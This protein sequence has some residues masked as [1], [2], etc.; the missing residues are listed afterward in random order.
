[1]ELI[2][3]RVAE[4]VAATLPERPSTAD[5]GYLDV[6]AAAVYL[7]CDPQRVYDLVYA[8]RLRCAKDGR[9]SVFKREWLD[10]ALEVGE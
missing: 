7:A 1:V 4:R 5:D 9:R 3:E 6:G 10:D 2:A 8:G